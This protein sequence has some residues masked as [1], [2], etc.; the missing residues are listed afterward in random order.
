MIVCYINVHLL[1]LL[2]LLSPCS[3][4]VGTLRVVGSDIMACF[5]IGFT[6]IVVTMQCIINCV[7]V[8]RT[9][10]FNVYIDRM[11]LSFYIYTVGHKKHT[12]I[13]FIIT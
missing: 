8:Y 7:I 6:V 3:L 5:S 12:K 9:L 11:W 2:L 13:F 10:W 1:L 4:L